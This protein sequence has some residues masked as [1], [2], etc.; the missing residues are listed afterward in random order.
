MF[1]ASVTKTHIYKPKRSY[2][3]PAKT[4]GL[5][6]KTS[7]KENKK[8]SVHNVHLCTARCKRTQKPVL[9]SCGLVTHVHLHSSSFLTER[10]H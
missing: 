4:V 9:Q 7:E 1:I 8:D 5:K 3:I 2:Y 10:L 6:M